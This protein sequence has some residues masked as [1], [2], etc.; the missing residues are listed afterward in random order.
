M[1]ELDE[2]LLPLAGELIDEYG[3]EIGF[4]VITPGEYDTATG[5]S[6][7]VV[8][9][10]KPLKALI[11]SAATINRPGTLIEGALYRLTLA[12]VHLPREP[13]PR[14]DKA[15]VNGEVL[16][17]LDPISKIYSGQEVAIYLVQVGK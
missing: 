13:K 2:E 6:N 16:T 17:V 10:T 5:K 1:T 4:G 9:Q 12:A 3:A 8:D 14:Q 7:P 11:E 15:I